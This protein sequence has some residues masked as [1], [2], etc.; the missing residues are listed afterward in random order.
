MRLNKKQRTIKNIVYGLIN[1]ILTIII[2]FITRTVIINVLGSEYLGLN[3]L[4]TSILQILNLTELGIS[5]AIVYA[6]YKPIAEN[7]ENKICAL[8]NLYKKLYRIIGIV[9]LIMGLVLIPFLDK[10]ITGNVPDDIN[11]YILY[12][13][14]LVNVFMTYVLFAYK[15][16]ILVA[17]QRNDIV[18]NIN[19]IL[20]LIQSSIQLILVF[21]LRNYY[22]YII[23]M[24]IFTIINNIVIAVL[25]KKKYPQYIGRG[26][27]DKETKKD[28]KKKISGL[29]VYRICSATRNSLDSIVISAFFGL[30]LVAIYNNYYLIL[31]SIYMLLCVITNSMTSGIGNSIVLDPVKKN[32]EDMNK[33]NFGYMLIAGWCTCCLLCL[34]QPFMKIWMGEEN[35]LSFS[36]VILFSIYFYSLQIGNI[37][38][39]YS[40]A[41]GLWWETRYRAILETIMNIVLNIILGKL[42]GING[43]ILATILSLL[44]INFGYGSLIIFRYYFKG[45]KAREYY[46]DHLKYAFITFGICVITFFICTFVKTGLILELI[47]KAL[48]CMIIPAILYYIIYRKDSKFK[49]IKVLINEMKSKFVKN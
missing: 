14:Y 26:I 32:Y 1:K 31:N 47:I 35:L 15:S 39:V 16:S 22:A 10:L 7:D 20:F 24:P 23:I 46:R 21:A 41:A 36:S 40:D 8:L 43:I 19:S 18:S 25:V 13:I 49:Y 34:Y 30:N 28:I 37:R 42:F 29:F 3:S 48:L 11:I 38:A 9:I 45:E 2:P 27:V 17:F 44:I 6:M 33:F 4:F 5:S 12:L